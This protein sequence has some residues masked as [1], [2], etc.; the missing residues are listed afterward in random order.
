MV[1][2]IICPFVV[3]DFDLTDEEKD[4]IEIAIVLI[5]AELERKK[6][7]DLKFVG[8][9][10]YPFYLIPIVKNVCLIFDAL[11]LFSEKIRLKDIETILKMDPKTNLGDPNSEAFFDQIANFSKEIDTIIHS[12]GERI[13]LEGLLNADLLKEFEAFLKNS[14]VSEEDLV[15][16][17]MIMSENEV[18]ELNDFF[19]R[20]FA[21]KLGQFLE[22]ELNTTHSIN[23]ALINV[24]E[25]CKKIIDDYDTKINLLNDLINSIN[26]NDNIEEIRKLHDDYNKKYYEFDA[27][28]SDKIS[29]AERKI[30]FLYKAKDSIHNSYS[31][32]I[33]YILDIQQEIIDLGITVKDELISADRTPVL[34]Y[35]PIYIIEYQNKKNRFHFVPPIHLEEKKKSTQIYEYN[36]SLK[37]MKSILDKNFSKNLFVGLQQ[38]TIKNLLE[39][40]ENI[41]QKFYDGIHLLG[42]K[43]WLESAV[44]V[45]V[46]DYFN[47]YFSRSSNN[48]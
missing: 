36:K 39:D 41:K 10:Y 1:N 47:A 31:S 6:K 14:K 2:E 16:V 4:K 8:K 43:K 48:G 32:L 5:N 23:S 35:V 37:N 42:G 38:S 33:A 11:K 19:K 9:V 13:Q 28:R 15:K 46:I 27:D 17:N 25:Q 24:Y 18:N 12:K 40:F 7:E 34:F 21:L 3:D 30:K 45:K 22:Y 26:V 44:Y 29:K 20:L